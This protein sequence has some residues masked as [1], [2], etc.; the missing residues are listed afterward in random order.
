MN[1]PHCQSNNTRLCKQKTALGYLQSRCR[2]CGQQFNERTATAFNFIQYP[3]EVVMLAV[4]YY[5]RFRNSLDDVV[6][7]IGMR[8]LHLSHQTI[9]N[10]T[11][12]FGVELGLKL[13]ERRKGGN[14]KK[15]HADATYIQV[16]A[17]G[18]IFIVRL[19]MKAI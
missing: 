14:S 8:G 3:T 17:D 4:H 9:H 10:W 19:I 12:T 5:Y 7:L 6:A 13:R 1:C 16:E 18:V 2:G 15:W 11:Q